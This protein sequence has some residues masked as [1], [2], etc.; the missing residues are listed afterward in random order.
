M[1]FEKSPAQEQGP[2][3][4]IEKYKDMLG[5]S[6]AIFILSADA[7]GI[8]EEK[9]E[10]YRPDSYSDVEDHGSMGGGHARV[11]AAA[12]VGQYFPDVKLVATSL[13][14]KKSLSLARVYAK[15]LG[16]LGIPEEQIRLEEKST[17]TLT[18]L[19]EMV[20]MAKA[21][22]WEGVAVLTSES[23]LERV[24]E[25]MNKLGDLAGGLDLADKEFIDAWESFGKGKSLQVRF[26][27]AEEILPMRDPRYADIIEKTKS[28]E[29]YKK[30]V[31]AEKRGVQ[32]IKDG[33]YGKKSK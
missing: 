33:T 32:Q 11:I 14:P 27:S 26:L 6:E 19:V 24:R 28:T 8:G 29:I 10:K 25:M 3:D 30:T 20:K 1:R 9:N 23:H 7:R 4:K 22:S 2:E 31:A 18:E 13:A 5:G 21:N 16:N 17:S 12:E 15:E